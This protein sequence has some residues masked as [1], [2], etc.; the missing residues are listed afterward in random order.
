LPKSKLAT[1]WHCFLSFL[2]IVKIDTEKKEIISNFIKKEHAKRG[3]NIE[4][5]FSYLLPAKYH[6]CSCN[7]DVVLVVDVIKKANYE[8][9]GKTIGQEKV[10]MNCLGHQFKEQKEIDEDD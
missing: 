8:T 6:S 10:C 7:N 2:F 9:I 4:A 5:V 1:Y 3:Y